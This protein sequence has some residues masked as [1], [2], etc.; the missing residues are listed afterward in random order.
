MGKV[1]VHIAEAEVSATGGMGRIAYQWREA[2]RRRG[3]EFIH[4]GPKE[5]G[6]M[7]HKSLFRKAALA[8]Y[9]QMEKK[10]DAFLVH[11]PSAGAFVKRGVPTFLFSHGIERRGLGMTAS[12]DRKRSFSQVLRGMLTAPLWR[13]RARSCDA[14]FHFASKALL[15]N[16][17][18]AAYAKEH[19]GLSAERIMVFRNGVDPV[20]QSSPVPE[21]RVCRALFLASWIARKGIADLA[22]AAR[23][24]HSR[25]VK[26]EWILAGTGVER[27]K[28]L[29]QW[30]QELIPTTTVIPRFDRP[31]EGELYAGSDLFVLPTHYEGQPLALLQAMA[32]R[33]C[34]ITTDCCGQ[35]D[36][37]QSGT[38]GLLHP[39]GDTGLLANM[40]EQC[41]LNA[42][43]RQK[44]GKNAAQSVKDRSWE[45]V[46]DEV[47]EEIHATLRKNSSGSWKS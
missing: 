43:L 40:I 46:S 29:E 19:Y 8:T 45:A 18:D 41:A 33:L 36:L 39:A 47:V 10:A 14:G 4:I 35:S 26:L 15:S 31:K 11:E 22:E 25:N 12:V 38:N 34:C 42:E 3:D 7:L 20:P 23:I 2:F 24:L 9:R 44:M 37:I 6:R 32:W 13:L 5:V 27:D 17:Q 16:W 1:I 28:V 21:N 30:P